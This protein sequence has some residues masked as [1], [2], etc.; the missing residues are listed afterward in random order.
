MPQLSCGIYQLDAGAM[1]TQTSHDEDEVY[2]V[3]QG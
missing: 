2:F 1:D 3:L